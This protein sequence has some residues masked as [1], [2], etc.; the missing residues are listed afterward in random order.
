MDGAPEPSTR[1]LFR[2]PLGRLTM[3]VCLVMSITAFEVL[4]SATAMPAALDDLGG[5][6]WY[7]LALSAQLVTALVAIPYGGRLIDRFGPARPMAAALALFTLGLVGAGAAPEMALVA[8]FRG[9]QGLGGGLLFVLQI[10]VVA[11][12]YP[13][14]LKA[15]M[16]ALLSA[17]WI[18]PGIVG[19]GIAGLVAD[20]LSW[21]WVFWGVVP[22]V[23]ATAVLALPPVARLGGVN[24]ELGRAEFPWWG[25]VGLAGGVLAFSVC[26][27]SSQDWLLPVAALG[28]VVAVVA[29]RPTLPEGSLR[30]TPGVPAAVATALFAAMGYLV[31]EQFVP[32]ALTELKGLSNTA[33]GLPLTASALAWTTGSAVVARVPR[34]RRN[35]TAMLGGL[36]MA[37]GLGL[38]A[39][40][41]LTDIPYGFIYLTL[42]VAAF[43]MGLV[44][45]ADQIVAV[46]SSAPGQEAT[47][48]AAVELANAL[49]IAAG[50]GVAGAFVG[51][52]ADHLHTGLGL[53]FVL[54]ISSAVVAAATARRLT[55]PER[56]VASGVEDGAGHEVGPE[57]REHRQVQQAGG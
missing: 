32:L 8:L 17:V 14:P 40:V 16:L 11:K 3:G 20:H 7:G 43:G 26:A 6:S 27:R 34:E 51:R 42:G 24:E 22:L 45:T 9:V 18:L 47:T 10:G 52:F 56:R 50:A 2:G 48:G 28:A 30:A 46:E 21:R 4:G 12:A 33:A 15:R 57:G 36:I 23:G 54:T 44:F 38:T 41:V 1:D 13:G 53:A 5:I 49:G 35:A 55:V 29:L 39:G 31:T 37:A 25:P 19:P